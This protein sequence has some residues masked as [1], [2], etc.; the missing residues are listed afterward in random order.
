MYG[1]HKRLFVLLFN[2]MPVALIKS[3]WK[4]LVLP[5]DADITNK[6]HGYTDTT[7]HIP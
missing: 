6:D 2:L 1:L 7:S 3:H 4:Q 5:P